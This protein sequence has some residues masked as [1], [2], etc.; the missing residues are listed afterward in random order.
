MAQI[1]PSK[2][3]GAPP[4]QVLAFGAWPSPISSETVAAASIAISDLTVC[5]G[6]LYWLETRP[7]QGGRQ[8][9]MSLGASGAVELT[10]AGFNVRSRVHEIGGAPYIVSGGVIYFANFADQRLYAQ[11]D[12]QAPIAITPTGYRYADFTA[13]GRRLIC[14]RE[15]HTDPANIRNTVVDVPM[16]GGSAGEVL[17]GDSDFVASPRIS[18]D[19]RRLAWM[20][21][22]HPAMPW[23][24]T[25]LYVAD[26][27]EGL[28]NITA[29]AGGDAVSAIEP[30]WTSTGDLLFMSDVEGYWNIRAW[31]GGADTPVLTQPSEFARPPWWLGQSN[32]VQLGSSRILARYADAGF[33][34]LVD[35]DT[36]SNIRRD[37]ASE[38]VEC[39][40][41]RAMSDE[42]VAFVGYST[43]EN[44]AIVRLDVA[45][46][47][48]KIL[49]RPSPAPVAGAAISVAT[50]ITF[51]TQAGEIAHAFYY[52]P[53][54]P[55]YDGPSNEKP[56]L[57]IAVHGGPTL[58]A[59]AAF[60]IAHQYWTSR[61]FAVLDVN[62]G[63][64]AGYGRKYRERLNGAW[65]VI[66]IQDAQ[67][68][69]AFLI[70]RGDVDPDRIIIRGASAGGFATLGA[71]TR[72]DRFAA[73]SCHY[74][75]SDL[76]ILL[77]E[78][79][80]FQS[81][82]LL[83]L[84][85]LY[86]EQRAKYR[87]RSPI[88]NLAGF[89]SPLIMFQGSDDLITPP[90][91]ARMIRDALD[92]CG[93]PVAYLEFEG[94]GHGFRRAESMV[95]ILNAEQYFFGK[96]LG[97]QPADTLEPISILNLR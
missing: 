59:S 77:R 61:G 1:P 88:N 79:H 40:C 60:N 18:Q 85:G 36:A 23:D 89:N 3:A 8:V 28:E 52:P 44:P 20:A 17:Y 68:G 87:D 57:I 74:G 29:V 97:F 46:G 58:Q 45:S 31:R 50:A 72:S 30:Q 2:S 26:L 33:D 7:H 37:I 80:K 9:L 92:G 5:E 16:A 10:P 38:F 32:Y 41:I 13:A 54:H 75:I 22:N 81:H 64:S 91:Q 86:P 11:R 27:V 66:E 56:P 83:T 35:L 15:D 96:V 55:D 21:W 93:K 70:A 39:H 94:E 48:A 53:T 71:L 90:N 43:D 24:A 47:R 78:T 84:L 42:E 63:G 76:E 67:A 6:T 49:H 4:R 82:Y 14:V 73:G 51:P 25:T 69:A 95:R 12:G 19:G 62:Y 65:G 34:S